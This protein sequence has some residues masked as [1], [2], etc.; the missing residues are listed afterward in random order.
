MAPKFHI[1]K[2]IPA[3]ER[4]RAAALY[5][6]AFS[7]KLGRVM[8]PEQ[9][10]LAFLAAAINPDFGYAAIAQDGRLLGVAGFKTSEGGLVGGGFRS[11]ARVYGVLGAMWRA[12][13]LALLERKLEP[14]L[15]LM[16]GICVAPEARGL[17]IGAALLDAVVAEAEARGLTAV[18][19]DVI[20]SNPRARALYERKGFRP[21]G[22]E[23]IGPLRWLFGFQTATTLLKPVETSRAES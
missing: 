19:L 8:R 15:L 14:D 4:E 9:K 11:L 20:D 10:A 2:G 6:V 17:G 3:G 7:S 18:R 5:W 21:A 23:T 1:Q 22:E 13:L 12:P 16:D